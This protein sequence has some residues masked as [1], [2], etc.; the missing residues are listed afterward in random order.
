MWGQPADP[1]TNTLNVNILSID[2][3]GGSGIRTL[4]TLPRPSV[5]KTGAFDHSAKPPLPPIY[6]Q[7]FDS[8]R[9]TVGEFRRSIHGNRSIAF[10]M[11]HIG[12][13]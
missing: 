8:E 13:S 1:A 11:N 10:N 2:C 6:P 7:Q 12:L 4:G 5:F 3:G 9:A